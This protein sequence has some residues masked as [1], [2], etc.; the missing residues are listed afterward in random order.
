MW[1]AQSGTD[2]GGWYVTWESKDGGASWPEEYSAMWIPVRSELYW[3]FN[4][5][6][7]IKTR[8]L[9]NNVNYVGVSAWSAPLALP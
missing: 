2:T 7:L 5:P 9:G 3:A 6:C 8:E 4:A 1:T